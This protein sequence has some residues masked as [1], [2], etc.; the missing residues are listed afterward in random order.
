MTVQITDS[1]LALDVQP[2][3]ILVLDDDQALRDALPETLHLRLP[4]VCVDVSD[5]P[6]AALERIKA[7]D[8]HAIITDLTMP[9]LDG[10]SLL[11]EVKRERPYSPVLCLTGRP[12]R[13]IV[14]QAL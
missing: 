2:P 5:C 11:R 9:G 6:Q 13:A 8:Y 1:H 14:R 10:L 12:D 7:T 3:Q 4:R